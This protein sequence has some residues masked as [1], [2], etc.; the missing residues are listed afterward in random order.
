[1][2][3]RCLQ[4]YLTKNEILMTLK[5]QAKVDPEFTSVVWQKL[6]EQNPS[7]FKAYNIQLQLKDQINTFNYLQQQQQQRMQ[8]GKMTLQQHPSAFSSMLSPNTSGVTMG[9]GMS[10]GMQ[11]SPSS[12][13][14]LPSPI[15]TDLDTHAFF[16]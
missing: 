5:A 2:I 1:M 15:K 16:T 8:Q 6:E 13:L 7:F 12:P 11:L 4:Q 14:P 9:M 10:M 3:E